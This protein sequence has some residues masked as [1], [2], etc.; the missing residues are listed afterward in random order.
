MVDSTDNTSTLIDT[1]NVILLTINVI[2]VALW[3]A[4][5]QNGGAGS[6]MASIQLFGGS[7]VTTAI[8]R[9]ELNGDQRD[10]L[11]S[12]GALDPKGVDYGM[13]NGG[14]TEVPWEL[15]SVTWFSRF[16]KLFHGHISFQGDVCALLQISTAERENLEAEIGA[17]LEWIKADETSRTEIIE[18]GGSQYYRVGPLPNHERVIERIQ[19]VCTRELGPDRGL[20]LSY[21]IQNDPYFQP[22]DDSVEIQVIPDPSSPTGYSAEFRVKTHEGDTITRTGE[23]TSRGIMGTYENRYDHMVDV[24]AWAPYLCALPETEPEVP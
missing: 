8:S 18:H 6:S 7:T 14:L 13:N 22:M 15:A 11:P 21:L 16:Q 23:L 10:S 24:T 12:S 17:I 2:V 20:I 3:I 5:A 19:G 4:R 9:E 1:A